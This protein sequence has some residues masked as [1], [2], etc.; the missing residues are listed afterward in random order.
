MPVGSCHSLS[1]T[2]SQ[3]ALGTFEN[4]AHSGQVLMLQPPR[5]SEAV[6]QGSELQAR[7]WHTLGLQSVHAWGGVFVV[8]YLGQ[9]QGVQKTVGQLDS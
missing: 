1:L 8:Q 9:G 7:Y 5:W 6:S 3:G 2:E 4:C